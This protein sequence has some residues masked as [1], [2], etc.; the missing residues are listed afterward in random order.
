MTTATENVTSGLAAAIRKVV[1]VGG[2][3]MG[4]GIAQ[5]F[6]TH[7]YDV[8]IVDARQEF[9]DR[10]LGTIGKNLE[11]VAKKLNWDPAQSGEVLRRIQ[12]GVSLELPQNRGR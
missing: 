12:G 8:Q 1:V 6:A 2:G 3:T 4:N 5:V 10:A 7:G 9:I 11:R